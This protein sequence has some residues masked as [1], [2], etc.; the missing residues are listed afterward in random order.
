ML[1]FPTPSQKWITFITRAQ[2]A[3]FTPFYLFFTII[4]IDNVAQGKYFQYSRVINDSTIPKRCK[5]V[6]M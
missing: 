1:Y 6:I 3:D 4:Y 5:H 2:V